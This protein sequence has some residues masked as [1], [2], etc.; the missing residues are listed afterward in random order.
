M[1]SKA[2]PYLIVGPI[3]IILAF[4]FYWMLRTAL[5][6]NN[7]MYLDPSNPLPVQFSWGGFRRVFGLAIAAIAQLQAT[8]QGGELVGSWVG[9]RQGV[10]HG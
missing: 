5:S 8:G 7:V 10:L 3:S 4:P 6:T 9:K 1:R 2:T